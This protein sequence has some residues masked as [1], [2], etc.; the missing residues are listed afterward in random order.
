MLSGVRSNIVCHVL[1]K[2]LMEGHP[3]WYY[4]RLITLAFGVFPW[5]LLKKCYI[6]ETLSVH[7]LFGTIIL[8]LINTILETPVAHILF[9]TTILG[10]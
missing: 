10:V 2:N 7:I 3:S 1:S 9:G 4:S 6:R 8:L 5:F